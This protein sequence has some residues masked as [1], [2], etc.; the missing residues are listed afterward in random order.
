LD[1]Q[2]QSLLAEID[3]GCFAVVLIS[4]CTGQAA[5]NFG[6]LRRPGPGDKWAN[7]TRQWGA[8]AGSP[9]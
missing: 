3:L 5:G 7:Q 1:G 9:S 4:R 6:P 8:T 2:R